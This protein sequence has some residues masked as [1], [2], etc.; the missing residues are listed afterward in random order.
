ML[1]SFIFTYMYTR[2]DFYTIL[3]TSIAIIMVIKSTK[4]EKYREGTTG[5]SCICKVFVIF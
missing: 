1:K 5:H 3:N 2:R 4:W